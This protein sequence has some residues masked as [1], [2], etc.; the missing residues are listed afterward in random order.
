MMTMKT[1]NGT[2]VEAPVRKAAGGRRRAL[3]ARFRPAGWRRARALLLALGLAGA[4]GTGSPAAAS[5][6]ARRGL[7]PAA[8]L[9][10]M[11]TEASPR[12]SEPVVL[13]LRL[14]ERCAILVQPVGEA[15]AVPPGSVEAA[16]VGDRTVVLTP[17]RIGDAELVLLSGGTHRWTVPLRIL[18][19]SFAADD[20]AD[21]E[22]GERG[23]GREDSAGPGSP[24]RARR[25]G[26]DPA[27]RPRDRLADEV[28]TGPSPAAMRPVP[29]ASAGEAPGAASAAGPET[30]VRTPWAGRAH[31]L[32]EPARRGTPGGA[33]GA[34]APFGR[35][36]AAPSWRADPPEGAAAPGRS[37]GADLAD[38][39][40]RLGGI[41]RSARGP[42]AILDGRPVEVGQWVGRFRVESIEMDR[43]VLRTGRNLVDLTL[44]W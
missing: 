9:S 27:I 22:G 44:P 36:P 17:R 32:R 3:R 41:L 28:A 35:A 13:T 11:M 2:G 43:V 25:G 12:L 14:G 7:G 42:I 8:D 18:P 4:G 38:R 16:L 31:A 23:G 6:G 10:R 20:D 1:T 37:G 34:V 19:G 29:P 40:P 30:E 33:E 26:P 15:V 5:T 39:P 21:D 24:A